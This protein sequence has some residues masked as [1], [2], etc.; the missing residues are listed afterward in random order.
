MPTLGEAVFVLLTAGGSILGAV[1]IWETDIHI[2][3][4]FSTAAAAILA[5]TR[6]KV[7]WAVLEDAM[8]S[9]ILMGMQVILILYT[10]GMLIGSWILS[11]V[12]PSMIYYGLN[13]ISPS[14][15]LIATLVICGIVSLATGTSWGTTGTVGIALLGIGTGLG[16][17]PAVCAG[18]AIS[19]AYFGDKMSPLSDTTNLAPAMAGTDLFQHIR[20]MLWTTAPT[21][22]V[23]LI[24]AAFMS[25]QYSSGTLNA[26]G[27]Q[28]LQDLM[29]SEFS[30]SLWSFAAP[31]LVIG[32]AAAHMPAIP[33][34]FAGVLAGCVLAVFQGADT[35][36]LLD[37][38]Q[39]GYKPVLSA[40]IVSA[41]ENFSAI[42][43]I[44]AKTGAAGMNPERAAGAAATLN[45]L[46]AR[47]GLQS[48]NW[49]VSMIL[50]ALSFGGIL[51]R[52]GFLEVLLDA[53]LKKVRTAAGLVASVLAACV[54]ANIFAGDQYIAI[55]LPGRMFKSRFEQ[56][57][58]HAR[59]LSRSL[60]D[61][62][63]LTSALVPWNT[64]GAYQSKA[65]GVPTMEYLPYAVFNWLNPV[66]ALLMTYMGIGIAWRRE[67]GGFVISRTKP[68]SRTA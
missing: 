45:T 15:F 51:D 24:L 38:L 67:D 53:L 68:D 64:C 65:L 39:N 54:L 14:I 56:W 48:M 25:R 66:I 31:L 18:F 33:S 36:A 59:M 5:M 12:V 9:S 34:I 61:C 44:L 10:V 17:P 50:C 4:V 1:R 16:I 35:G 13:V 11:G 8:L 3:L 40:S 7:R 32:L 63:T 46:L 29:R 37:V 23:V 57:G 30:I 2:P 22:A 28:A 19:G 62:G 58:L 47:G 42:T 49:T 55:V 20:A 21:C 41:G 52:C 26:H 60:E 6:M 27:I 43:G